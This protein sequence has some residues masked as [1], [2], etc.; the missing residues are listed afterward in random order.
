MGNKKKENNKRLTHNGKKELLGG[1]K[2]LND[3]L[4]MSDY[5][6]NEAG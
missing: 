2:T 5:V 1:K 3:P 6:H 4:V